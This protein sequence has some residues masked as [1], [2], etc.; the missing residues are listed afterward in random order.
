MYKLEFSY[1]AK[2]YLTDGL[3]RRHLKMVMLALLNFSKKPQIRKK[4]ITQISKNK[5]FYR[6]RFYYHI[7][8]FHIE[9]NVTKV[10]FIRSEINFKSIT[11]KNLIEEFENASDEALIKTAEVIKKNYLPAEAI[12]AIFLK[13]KNHILAYREAFGFIQQ[14]VADAVGIS[15]AMIST[16]ERGKKVGSIQT[17]SAIAKFFNIDPSELMVK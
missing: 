3:S 9:E 1:Q 12:C 11:Q 17:I 7:V 14:E 5:P 4:N 10:D 13:K 6:L 16:I 15:D 2:N 8:I